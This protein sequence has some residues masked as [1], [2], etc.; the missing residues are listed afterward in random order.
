MKHTQ[1]LAINRFGDVWA[2]D[3]YIGNLK[4]A[5]TVEF[6]NSLGADQT[7]TTLTQIL[8]KIIEQKFYEIKLSDYFSVAVGQGNPFS[9]EL[10]NWKTVKSRSGD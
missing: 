2:P 5:E 8:P 4:D 1:P 7:I 10:F 9:E 3:R 6:M